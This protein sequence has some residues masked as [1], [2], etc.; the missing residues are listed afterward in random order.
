MHYLAWRA[1]IP[2]RVCGTRARRGR[3]VMPTLSRSTGACG[4][5]LERALVRGSD[6]CAGEDAGLATG[7]Q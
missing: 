5:R 6:G 7:V 3:R 4:R 2:R 1:T